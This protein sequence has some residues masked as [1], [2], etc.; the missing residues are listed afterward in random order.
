MKKI[1][2]VRHGVTDGNTNNQYQLP[3]TPLSEKGIKQAN[4]IAERLRN[5]G[6]TIDI[7]FASPMTR[8][9]ETGRII[10]DKLE[11]KLVE[12]EFFEE[13]KRPTY[14]RG[15][16]K[17]DEDVKQIMQEVESNFGNEEWKHSDEENYFLLNARVNKAVNF[18]LDTKEDNILIVSHGALLRMLLA[19]I[20]HGDKLTPEI[21]D[22]I[23]YSFA[24]TNTGISLIEYSERGW[25]VKT[26]NDHDH[27]SEIK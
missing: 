12:N 18:I 26:W 6:V 2:L 21:F 1:Y 7:I 17:E 20:I 14:V 13:M 19:V 25:Y 24:T 3:T 11:V 16:N 4:F 8:A 22:G 10:A 27:L 9:S 23:Y 15:K 5:D